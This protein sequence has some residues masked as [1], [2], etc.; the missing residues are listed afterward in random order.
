ME[1]HELGLNELLLAIIN[2]VT[3]VIAYFRGKKSA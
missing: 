2:I 1:L 3:T